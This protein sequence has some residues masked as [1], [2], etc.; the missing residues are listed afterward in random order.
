MGGGG[1]RG[2]AAVGVGWRQA[3]AMASY[4]AHAHLR[5]DVAHSLMDVALLC[6]I[7]QYRAVGATWRHW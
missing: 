2:E 1:V 5:A 4:V 3:G 6:Y 7:V